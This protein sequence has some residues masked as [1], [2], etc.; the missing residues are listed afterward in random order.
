[1]TKEQS[2]SLLLQCNGHEVVSAED[3]D[4]VFSRV[5]VR[6]QTIV[7]TCDYSFQFFFSFSFFLSFKKGTFRTIETV[8]NA[9]GKTSFATTAKRSCA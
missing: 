5:M 4:K 2:V 9:N 3:V 8:K 6:K 7:A 1:M